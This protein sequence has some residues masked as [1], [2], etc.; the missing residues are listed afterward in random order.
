MHVARLILEH[1]HQLMHFI[2]KLFPE[3]IVKSPPVRRR[4]TALLRDNLVRQFQRLALPAQVHKDWE[5]IE[6]EISNEDPEI[7]ALC[8]KVLRQTP[9]IAKFSRTFVVKFNNLEDIPG[10]LPTNLYQGLNGKTFAV[11]VKRSGQHTF[12]SVDVER[13]VGGWVLEHQPEAKVKLD[14]PERKIELEVRGDR[15]FALEETWQGMGGYPLGSQGAVLSLLSGGYD[16]SVAIYQ[17]LRRGL[18]THFVFFNLGGAGHELAVREVASQIHAEFASSHSLHFVSVNFADIVGALSKYVPGSYSNILLKRLM[19]KTAS[20]IGQRMKLP[21]LVTGD[22][23]AQVS[24]QTLT[25][26]SVTEAAA[27][28]PI[29]RPLITADKGTIIDIARSI[30]TADIAASIPEYCGINSVRPT[31]EAKMDRVEQHESR[32]PT[33]LIEEAIASAK[34]ISVATLLD[35]QDLPEVRSY[36][37]VPNQARVIDIR[38]P[39]E[40]ENDP[41]VLDCD[42]EKIPFYTIQKA[43]ESRQG[44]ELDL[45]YCD[46]GLLSRLHA[47]LLIDSGKTNIAIYRPSR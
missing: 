4:Q 38:H 19:L 36:S 33:E 29:L 1:R 2:V 37:E 30:G 44:S 15:V 10:K 14:K 34:S 42:V 41:L 46:R 13:L 8:E 24:S 16:S 31:T 20:K 23:V 18:L 3:I 17:C 40:I 7:A 9:G 5:K 32:L 22:S 6:V 21:A 45:L 43:F 25:N 47:E 12:N 26:L 35:E 27:E 39:E 28:L 11:R